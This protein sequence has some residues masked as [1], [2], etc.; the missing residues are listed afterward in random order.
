MHLHVSAGLMHMK[1][2]LDLD[3]DLIR[4]ARE[5]TGIE[6]KTALIHAGLRELIARAAAKRLAAMGGTMPSL[7]VPPRRRSGRAK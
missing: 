2:T 3:E 1:T 6:K 5:Y 7:R 4:E